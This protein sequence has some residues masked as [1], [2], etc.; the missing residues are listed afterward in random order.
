MHKIYKYS[1][2]QGTSKILLPK[3]ADILCVKIQNDRPTLWALVDVDTEEREERVIRVLATG[4]DSVE[5]PGTLKFID[6]VLLAGGQLV[7]HVFEQ[8]TK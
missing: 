7:Y 2:R 8:L 3:N 5:N 6:T 1:I 4:F